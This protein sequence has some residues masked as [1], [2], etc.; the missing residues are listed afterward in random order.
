MF[1]NMY[2]FKYK[3][4]AKI[5]N[6]LYFSQYI[7][8]YNYLIKILIKK[9]NLKKTK[10]KNK[11]FNKIL[12]LLKKL[13][14]KNY[15]YENSFYRDKKNNFIYA[16]FIENEICPIIKRF[17]DKYMNN[18]FNNYKLNNKINSKDIYYDI[19]LKKEDIIINYV[20]YIFKYN[21]LLLELREI[22]KNNKHATYFDNI[23]YLISIV[24]NSKKISSK[25]KYNHQFNPHFFIYSQ[26]KINK[27]KSKLSHLFPYPNNDYLIKNI[28]KDLLQDSLY[29]NIIHITPY[30]QIKLYL[31]KKDSELHQ[32][33][34]FRLH[35]ILT[36][37]Q[38]FYELANK[39]KYKINNLLHINIDGCLDGE[40]IV[41]NLYK[42]PKSQI[43]A[44]NL[45]IAN[46]QKL[47]K[48][49]I[50]LS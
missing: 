22:M 46:I 11:K 5:F 34:N 6:Y 23:E 4:F 8:F 2:F 25:N 45:I 17:E 43:C 27:I 14:A 37:F 42:I 31:C 41:L 48:I 33:L 50:I 18:S 26:L 32:E 16:I 39:Y 7:L 9:N 12:I 21:K 35:V 24:C 38:L 47:I 3:F 13:I 10:G 44:N 20:S 30:Q 29:E 28:S 1:E 15:Y 36:Q 19:E 40:D 49:M